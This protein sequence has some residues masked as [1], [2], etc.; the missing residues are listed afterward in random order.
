MGTVPVPGVLVVV[1][2]AAAVVGGAAVVAPIVPVEAA[3]DQP[4]VMVG[5]HVAKPQP[6]N[7]TQKNLLETSFACSS[8]GNIS[9]AL[10]FCVNKN[11]LKLN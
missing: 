3:Q 6:P 2:G 8:L 1:G 4:L 10:H 7:H 11:N 5:L 9:L